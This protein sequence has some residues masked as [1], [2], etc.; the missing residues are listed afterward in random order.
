MCNIAIN[1][2]KKET[3]LNKELKGVLIQKYT[4]MARPADKIQVCCLSCVRGMVTV[5]TL[6]DM[7][8][9]SSE[10]EIGL[11]IFTGRKQQHYVL[12]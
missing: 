9:V 4:N 11:I 12:L 10:E 3:I 1:L 2:T 7:S 6:V 5:T 8:Q